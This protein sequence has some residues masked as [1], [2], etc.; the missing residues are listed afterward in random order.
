MITFE[1]VP[2][3]EVLDSLKA[4]SATHH[5]DIKDKSLYPTYFID[6]ATYEDLSRNDLSYAVIAKNDNQIIA[7]SCYNLT[8]DLN[9]AAYSIGYNV[10][11][12]IKREFR[13]KLVIEFLKECDK[14]LKS[15]NVQQ[16][17][18]TVSDIRIGK[19]LEKAGYKASVITW[20]KKL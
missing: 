14:L 12:F 16:V 15:K 17:L 4:N 8:I 13:G 2:L 6:W 9:N 11:I 20:G 7:Y 19:I 1:I 18:Y 5:K 3:H 10:A